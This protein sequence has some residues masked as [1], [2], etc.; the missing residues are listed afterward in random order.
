MQ[1]LCGHHNSLRLR[2]R[3][4]SALEIA[5]NHRDALD[6]QK[7][8]KKREY[9][10][11]LYL[12]NKDRKRESARR[13]YLLNEDKKRDYERQFYLQ[14]KDRKKD[15]IRQ[16]N[17]L[18]EDKKKDYGREY[19]LQNEDKTKEYFR[20]YVD[21]NKN[22][23]KELNRQLRARNHDHP[24]SYLPRTSENKS[25]KTPDAVRNYFESVS[26]ELGISSYHDWYRIS[27][28]QIHSLGGTFFFIFSWTQSLTF[29]R[30]PICKVWQP[31][32]CSALCFP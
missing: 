26:N 13:Y 1:L 29:R 2:L 20:Q 14:H 6:A 18:N 8:N 4:V 11:R 9:D 19:Y 10:R 15:Y 5:T 7:V 21:E 16:Y 23:V 3:Q 28:F 25:W 31:R 22:K 24:E 12:Q 30:K 27:S 32:Q 17:L